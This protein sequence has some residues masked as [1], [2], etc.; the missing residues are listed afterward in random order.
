MGLDDDPGEPF[1]IEMKNIREELE[2]LETMFVAANGN[3]SCDRF[4]L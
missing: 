1:K 4:F 2:R 3:E